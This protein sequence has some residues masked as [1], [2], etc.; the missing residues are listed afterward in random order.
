MRILITGGQGQLAQ[1]LQQQLGPFATL[2]APPRAALDL[3]DTA[4]LRQE[5][6][7]FAPDLIINAAAYTAV[8]KAQSEPELAFAINAIAPGVLAEEAAQLGIPLIHYSTDYVFDGQKATPYTESDATQPLNVYG[9]SKRAGELAI[10]AI[11][12]SGLILRTSWVYSQTGQNFLLTMQRLLREREHLR[13]VDDQIG[14]PTWTGTLAEVTAQLIQGWQQQG[15]ALHGLYHLTAL[16]ETSWYGFA[17]AIRAHL[18]QQGLRC[19]Q[20]E[21]I[22]SS[23]YPTPAARPHNSRLNCAALQA[24]WGIALPHW[25]SALQQCL[26]QPIKPS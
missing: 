15:L 19:A 24:H 17:S 13:V 2:S 21:P 7:Q 26:N 20:L 8:D 16:G 1:A 4:R 18:Q 3:T 10:Q 22:P 25:H 9:Q 5:V 14:A 11:A 23:E 6:R 12:G